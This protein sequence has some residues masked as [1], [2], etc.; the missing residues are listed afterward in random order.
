MTPTSNLRSPPTHRYGM[1]PA[2]GTKTPAMP[3]GFEPHLGCSIPTLRPHQ[4]SQAPVLKSLEASS[5][6][7]SSP[8][9]QRERRAQFHQ[10][11]FER[12]HFC[13]D[14]EHEVSPRRRL[15]KSERSAVRQRGPAQ[16]NSPRSLIADGSSSP[17]S[18]PRCFRAWVCHL[19]QSLIRQPATRISQGLHGVLIYLR[20][21]TG[22]IG[23]QALQAMRPPDFGTRLD[24]K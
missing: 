16:Q 7:A 17:R 21:L 4:H 3:R 18:G 13:L 9:T 5:S 20:H 6:V 2:N 15:Q 1:P 11:W 23:Q 24:A 8:G 10:G 14:R 22:S 12:H 19:L